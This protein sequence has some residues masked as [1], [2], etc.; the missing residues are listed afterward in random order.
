MEIAGENL[1]LVPSAITLTYAGGSN[2][3]TQRS[4]TAGPCTIVVPGA[5]IQCG[6]Q[7]G[8]GANYSFSVSVDGTTSSPSAE[9]LS[10]ATPVINAVEGPGAVDCPAA[11]GVPIFLRGVGAD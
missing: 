2:G 9:R 1:G 8:V 10:Y 7:P 4:Y 3:M 6:A 5:R 11:G